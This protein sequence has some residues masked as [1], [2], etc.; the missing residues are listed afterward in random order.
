MKCMKK[1]E[2][3]YEENACL[4]TCQNSPTFLNLVNPVQNFPSKNSVNSENSVIP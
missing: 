2:G 3:S 1:A 4:F